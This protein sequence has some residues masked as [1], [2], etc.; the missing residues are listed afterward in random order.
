MIK[1]YW[2]I[3]TLVAASAILIGGVSLYYF[4]KSSGSAQKGSINPSGQVAADPEIRM[5]YGIPA[6]SFRIEYGRVKRDQMLMSI[7]SQYKL[8]EGAVNKLL[9]LKQKVFD[10]R[11]IRAGNTY[12]AFSDPDST[13]YLRYLAY[14][15]TA[16]DYVVFSFTDSVT[17]SLGQK[18]V[19]T[20]TL[21]AQG[22]ISSSLWNAMID[23]E[24]N[25]LL[26]NDLSEI[27]A[28][29]IDFFGLQVADSF[30]V[31]YDE[32]FVDTVSVGLGKIHAAYFYHAGNDFFAIPFVQ[33]SVE[34]YY[35]IEGNSLRKTF[36][37]AP[38]NYRRVSS[39]FSYSRMHPVLKIRRPHLGVDYAAPA[40]TPVVS[41]GDGKIIEL[42][43]GYNKGGGNMIR[44]K[45]N[46]VYSTAYLHLQGFAKGIK[47]GDWVKQGD[48]IGY[49]GQ[50]GLATGPHLDFRFYMNGNPIDPLKVESPPVE[51]IHEENRE[52]F[53]SVKTIII[54][55]LQRDIQ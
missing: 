6:D 17:V 44:I 30:R 23:R 38:L 9:T 13:G 37:K 33:D 49:V 1:K 27:Y 32:H 50:T 11:K 16:I 21:R 3:L 5:E 43:P 29:S 4:L 2:K 35:D 7:L 18:A 46:G 36:L 51:P 20:L 8:P 19:D 12:A 53:D 55:D 22:T 42:K 47:T 52:K 24:I 40:G 45:H 15:H 25:P 39:H 34:S 31:I 41:I 10:V 48:V 28:W 26:A 54:G 14:E